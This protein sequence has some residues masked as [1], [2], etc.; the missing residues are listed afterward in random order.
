M[1]HFPCLVGNAGISTELALVSTTPLPLP[2]NG[3]AGYSLIVSF[4]RSL[5]PVPL[6]SSPWTFTVLYESIEAAAPESGGETAAEDTSTAAASDE[7]GA[8]AGDEDGAAAA[9][10]QE[11]Q[12]ASVHEVKWNTIQETGAYKPNKYNIVFRKVR[13]DALHSHWCAVVLVWQVPFC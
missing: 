7:D 8:A 6:P 3:S 13:V 4:H 9:E 2:P 10:T 11:I 12:P 1:C 5:A